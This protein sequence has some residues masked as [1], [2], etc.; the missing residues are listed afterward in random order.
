MLD[1]DTD[2]EPRGA[3]Y[4]APTTIDD[5][6][7]LLAENG[8]DAK[9]VAGGQSLFVFLRQGLLQPS[10]LIGLKKIEELTEIAESPGG[11]LTIGAMVSQHRIATDPLIAART[12]ALAEAAAAVASP[13]IRRQGTIGGNI[14]HADPTGDPPAALIALAAEVEIASQ[15]GRRRIPVAELFADYMETTL[16]PDE[17]LVAIHIPATIAGAAYLKHRVRGVDTALVGA[18]VGVTL[19][20]GVCTD[21]R[22]GLVGAGT[23]PIRAVDAEAA[24]R[25]RPV[26]A[27]TIAAAAQAASAECEPLSDTE[28][29]EWYRREMVAVFVRRAAE[30]ALR[31][32]QGE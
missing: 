10:Y 32:A 7:A 2:D 24:L 15:T 13:P 18:G 9:L 23:T 19:D 12:P 4:L 17:L 21:A 16:G 5:A 1:F 3:E 25:G 30:I 8:E 22:I 20:G 28:G 14:C 6:L 26:T 29:S 11:G 31:R 27:D